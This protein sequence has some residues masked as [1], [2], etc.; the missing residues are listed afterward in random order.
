M[1]LHNLVNSSEWSIVEKKMQEAIEA[2]AILDETKEFKD[3]AIEALANQ[4]M[5]TVL[6]KFLLDMNFYKQ[7]EVKRDPRTFK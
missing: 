7:E 6:G 1:S 2:S 5:K 4:R 3:I